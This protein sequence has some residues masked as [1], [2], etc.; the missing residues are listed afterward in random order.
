MYWYFVKLCFGY[1]LVLK[2]QNVFSAKLLFSL[3]TKYFSE[4]FLLLVQAQRN[5]DTKIRKR[6]RRL[7]FLGSGPPPSFLHF[8]SLLCCSSATFVISATSVTSAC[9]LDIFKLSA[10]DLTFLFD[11]KNAFS[12]KAQFLF[13]DYRSNKLS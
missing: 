10:M 2:M 7:V 13:Q 8:S 3:E 9:H 4:G 6:L 11:S 12:Q 5:Q 1:F